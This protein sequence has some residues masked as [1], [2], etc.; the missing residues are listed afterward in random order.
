M[1][2][3]CGI[4][5]S[6]VANY[7]FGTESALRFNAPEIRSEL[8]ENK[9]VNIQKNGFYIQFLPNQLR[10]T[11]YVDAHIT[12]ENQESACTINCRGVLE[13]TGNISRE[14]MELATTVAHVIG[15]IYPLF[16]ITSIKIS[17]VLGSDITVIS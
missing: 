2:L 8:I 1:L 6:C 16:K 5:C 4:I 15:E 13:M 17:N 10:E 14:L 12:S 9:T 3:L 7:S 11:L